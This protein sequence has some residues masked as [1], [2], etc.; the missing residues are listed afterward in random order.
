MPDQKTSEVFNPSD[1]TWCTVDDIW[2]FSRAMNFA[3]Q[4]MGDDRL[5]TVVDWGESSIKMRDA[6]G[7]RHHVGSVPSRVLVQ[8]NHT[9]C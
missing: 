6:R 8:Q 5:C 4:V 1:G 9:K 7:E 3:V 2:P